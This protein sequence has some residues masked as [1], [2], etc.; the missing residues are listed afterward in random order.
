MM[1]EAADFTLERATGGDV[2]RFHGVLALARLGD[3]PDRLRAFDGAV[4]RIDLSDVAHIDTIGA[5]IIHRFAAEKGAAIEGLDHDGE[6]LL[7]QVEQAD[8][9]VAMRPA[10]IGSIERIFEQQ[11]VCHLQIGKIFQLPALHGVALQ[12]TNRPGYFLLRE[13]WIVRDHALGNQR[14]HEGRRVETSG[15]RGAG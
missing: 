10:H 14:I 2:L 5:W 9:P 6:H 4:A 11:Q 12:S 13:K 1:T 8:Q 15:G 7:S 3:L